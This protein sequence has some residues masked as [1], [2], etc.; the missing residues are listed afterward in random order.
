MK[1]AELLHKHPEVFVAG[2]SEN[3]EILS[4][5]DTFPMSGKG[6]KLIYQ[7]SPNFFKF[8]EFHSTISFVFLLK[9]KG[10]IQGVGTLILRPGI[11]QGKLTVVGYLGDLR[12]KP[13]LRNAVIWR[14][15]YQDLMKDSQKIEEFC[16]GVKY[17]I[18]AVIDSNK[19]AQA[20]L[21]QSQKNSFAYHLLKNYW[22]INIYYKLSSKPT[23]YSVRAA[24]KEDLPYILSYWK[25]R[26]MKKEFG[27]PE[28]TE[29]A[30]QH[31]PDFN[32]A[33]ILLA[34]HG[35][36]II[37]M[38]GLWS[39]HPYKKIILK[40]LPPTLKLFSY[41]LKMRPSGFPKESEELR[42]LYMTHLQF[43]NSE[44]L[45]LLVDKAYSHPLM[46]EHHILSLALFSES[47][48]KE[49]QGFILNTIPISLYQVYS[50]EGDVSILNTNA[51]PGFEM[52]LV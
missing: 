23:A 43:N 25:E 15:F 45:R 22:M 8:L 37:G 44:V 27:Q 40:S 30:L 34:F 26:E 10:S 16:G 29:Y 48:V 4:F 7:R 32:P 13:G 35:S 19:E 3:E 36:E 47:E 21:I 12:V 49:L 20:S 41:F 51:S 33:R 46:K 52:A 14:K 39:P 17:F 18:T 11:I 31:W 5:F 50:K 6:F 24:R 38:C 9:I 42:P 2:P 1:L 28:G